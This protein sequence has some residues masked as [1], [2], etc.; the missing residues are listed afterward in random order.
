MAARSKPKY[1]NGE[2]SYAV[3]VYDWMNR[4]FNLKNSEKELYSYILAFTLGGNVY[5]MSQETASMAI[6][7]S[8]KTIGRNLKHLCDEG[9]ITVDKPDKHHGFCDIPEYKA[10]LQIL[11]DKEVPLTAEMLKKIESCGV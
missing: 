6:G 3:C 5:G 1:A 10:N 2:T 7:V 11:I 9:L 4:I 8:T